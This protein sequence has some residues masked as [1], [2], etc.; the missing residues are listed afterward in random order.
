MMIRALITLTNISWIVI[1]ISGL[2][3]SLWGYKQG[4]K[5]TAFLLF[6]IYFAA[7]LYAATLNR[8]VMRWLE[9]KRTHAIT[10]EM[11]DQYAQMQNEL[12][13]IYLKYPMVEPGTAV[14]YINFPFGQ[15]LLVL[16]VWILVK[17]GKES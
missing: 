7:S 14:R 10:Q 15:A 3:L 13:E 1:A 9:R 11:L 4:Y 8:P 17:K 16:G 2:A 12:Q 6:T 5:K